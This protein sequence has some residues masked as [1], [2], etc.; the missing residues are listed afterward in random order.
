RSTIAATTVGSRP[1]TRISTVGSANT[2]TSGVNSHSAIDTILRRGRRRGTVISAISAT[3]PHEFPA[4][5]CQHREH[6]ERG[7]H[8][9]Q[10]TAGRGGELLAEQPRIVHAHREAAL[11]VADLLV[12]L[13]ILGGSSGEALGVEL[14]FLVVGED[15]E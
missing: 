3:F 14:L 9:H 6:G 11:D 5:S 2:S 7:C 10:Q 1:A 4:P 13:A 15:L 8:R 12:D